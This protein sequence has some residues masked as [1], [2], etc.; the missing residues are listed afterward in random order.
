MSGP[1]ERRQQGL[2][3]VECV[4]NRSLR[5]E[6]DLLRCQL[7]DLIAREKAQRIE[8]QRLRQHRDAEVSSMVQSATAQ[9]KAEVE[10]LKNMLQSTSGQLLQALSEREQARSQ[11]EQCAKVLD[12]T[13]KTAAAQENQLAQRLQALEESF[14]TGLNLAS[15]LADSVE[16]FQRH[17]LP[18]FKPTGF[19]PK[20]PAVEVSADTITEGKLLLEQLARLENGLTLLRVIVDAKNDTLVLIRGKLKQENEELRAELQ[21]AQEAKQGS[22]IP[23]RPVATPMHEDS[24]AEKN[25][26]LRQELQS[27][28]GLFNEEVNHLKSKLKMYESEEQQGQGRLM[29]VQKELVDLQNKL[30]EVESSRAA[31]EASLKEETSARSQL[32]SQLFSLRKDNEKTKAELETLKLSQKFLVRQPRSGRI[33]VEKMDMMNTVNQLLAELNKI[34]GEKVALEE[35]LKAQ[36]LFHMRDRMQRTVT[37]RDVEMAASNKVGDTELASKLARARLQQLA[38]QDIGTNCRTTPTQGTNDSSVFPV[39]LSSSYK[40]DSSANFL[41]TGLQGTQS[42]DMPFKDEIVNC[43]ELYANSLPTKVV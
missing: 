3:E 24:S 22:Q 37:S 26:M 18:T 33:P 5:N 42:L 35:E 4:L 38:V 43:A 41:S 32:V 11:K 13:K 1:I 19:E 6:N 29:E 8:L 10:Q 36:K 30:G 7:N 21:V 9:L 17:V 15:A 2:S 39:K 40:M 31:L 34:K 27:L 16:A 28:Q 20:K 25:V 12:E 23:S 14:K